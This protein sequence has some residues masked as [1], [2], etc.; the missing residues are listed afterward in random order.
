MNTEAIMT[1]AAASAIGAA[2]GIPQPRIFKHYRKDKYPGQSS[3][4]RQGAWAGDGV[5]PVTKSRQQRRGE[6]IAARTEAT[7]KSLLTRPQTSV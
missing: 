4:F 5:V 6:R 3:A 7:I 2:S 1:M